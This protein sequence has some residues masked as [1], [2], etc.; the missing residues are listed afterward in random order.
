MGLISRVSSRT[1]RYNGHLTTKNPKMVLPEG[2]F[3]TQSVPKGQIYGVHPRVP[4]GW[5]DPKIHAMP[6]DTRPL[7]M[8]KMGEFFSW[9]QPEVRFSPLQFIYWNRR[10]NMQMNGW[11]K[12]PAGFT[13][14][15][16]LLPFV[17]AI[18]IFQMLMIS[19]PGGHLEQYRTAKYD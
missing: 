6:K 13:R 14:A 11:A 9:L 12:H 3:A 4:G 16:R 18:A 1:Y 8:V 10:K 2:T 15:G 7:R 17:G 19:V 5:A